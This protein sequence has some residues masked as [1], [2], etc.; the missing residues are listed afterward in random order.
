M[1]ILCCNVNFY[2]LLDEFFFICR[3]FLILCVCL[4]IFLVCFLFVVFELYWFFLN[5]L[6]LD[7]CFVGVDFFV[8][9]FILE[10]FLR[11]VL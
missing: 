1:F 2:K 6:L 10:K 3:V 7:D 11:G 9:L 4:L 5:E 8:D